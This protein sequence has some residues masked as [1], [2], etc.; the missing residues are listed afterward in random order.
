M[1]D[2]QSHLL[3]DTR[4]VLARP[5]KWLLAH[6][7]NIYTAVGLLMSVAFGLAIAGAWGF[8]EIAQ[9]VGEGQTQ[10]LDD[11]ILLWLNSHSTPLLDELALQITAVGNGLTVAVIGL[12]ACAFL[13][14]MRERVGVLLLVL[15][16]VGGDTF[17][18]VLKDAFHRPRPE[19]FMLETPYA[20][21]VSASFPSGHA[22]ASMVLYLVLA[23]LLVRL[24][25]KGVFRWVVLTVAGLL[26]V[27]I[28]VSRMYLGV[29]YPSDVL[30][31]YVFGFCWAVFCTFIIE[32]VRGLRRGRRRQAQGVQP[33]SEAPAPPPNP[34]QA[35]AGQPAAS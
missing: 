12:V 15:A 16:V 32:A 25:G 20:R 28:G 33:V 3:P 4:D 24:G 14:S 11:G 17:N 18:R 2:Q 10:Q 27:L 23:Y 19:L 13:W 5:L 30:A 34:G 22:T 9:A 26:I 31:G 8:A 35:G 21:P 29:H 6:V 1:S 7:H